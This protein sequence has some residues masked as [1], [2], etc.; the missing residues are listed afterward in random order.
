MTR[1]TSATDADRRGDARRH[2]RRLARGP[3]RRDP[4]RPCGSTARSTCPT[5]MS[6]QEV[7]DAPVRAGGAQPPRRR[8]D[9]ASSAPGCT[10]TTCRRWSTRSSRARSSS[11]PYTPYQPEIS[12]GGL[13]VMFEFQTAISELTGPAGVERL[14]VRGPAR[15]GRRGLPGQARDQ[16]LASSW[17]RAACTRTRA[18]RCAPTPPATGWSRGGGRAHRRGRHRR[19]RAWRRRRR[20]HRRGV[21]AAAQLPRHGRGPRRA[22]RGRQAHRRAVRGGR[23]PA[24]A[25]ASCGRRASSAPTSASARARRSATGSTSAARR[26]ASSPPTSASSAGCRAGSRARRATSTARRGFVLTLQT[27]E[28]H[29]RREKATHNICT[30]QALNALAGVVYLSWLGKRGL[31]ELARADAAAHPLRAR[32]RSG[33]EPINPGPVVRE[34]AV[35]VPR[36]RRAVRARPRRGRSTPATG[37]GATTPSTRTACWWRSPSAA[38]GRDIDR[39][40]EP[41]RGRGR[42]RRCGADERAAARPAR[43]TRR[44]SRSSSA[45]ARA[46]ARSRR[47]RSTC[48][49]CRWR[50]CF[51]RA[52]SGARR[53]SCPRSPSPRSCATS[54]AL[55]KKN[56]DLDTGFYPLGSCTMKHNPKLHERVAALP[57]HARLHPLQD[58]E[59]AQGALELMWRLQGALAEIAGPAARLA[60]AARRLARRAGRPAA[61][62]RLPRGPRRAA[63]QGAHARHRARHQPRH[64]DDGRLRG[65]Q[66]GH[67]RARRR[68]PR[69]PARQGRRR[70]GLPDAH[71]PEHARAVRP[72]HRGDRL[73]RARRG[74]HALL[75][76]GEPE[77][78]D[79]HLAARRHGLRHRPL[80]PAQVLHAAARRRRAG[81]RADRVSRTGSSRSCR[82]RRWCAASERQR[83]R[84]RASTSTTTG[85]SRSASCAASRATSACSCAPTPTSARSAATACAEASETAVL[86]ANYLRA[87]LAEEGVARVPAD[88]LRPHL[89]ARVRAVGRA[90]HATS[91]ASR[92]STSPSG[93]STTS[94]HPPTVYFPLLVDEA[95][96][97]EPTETETQGAA[98]PLR[99][100]RALDPRGGGRGPR[101]RAQRAVH[102]PGAA[103][104]RGRR[105]Q[106]AGRALARGRRESG[107]S[108]EGCVGRWRVGRRVVTRPF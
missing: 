101:D 12:Q 44:R 11:R 79:G 67:R 91:W 21:R 59:Y 4:R 42:A 70:R 104:R 38:R 25:R 47:P 107:R 30:A 58:P 66:G 23:R 99:R 34:F 24:A 35:R 87:R 103:P 69:R 85:P 15:R 100:R 61:H 68:G 48:P 94:V 32:E 76:R 43:A 27:R 95:L 31:V 45:R 82:G 28:Q 93:C 64:R 63:P 90:A 19:R 75:R 55:S 96:M 9:H 33:L 5:G 98:R 62:A 89:H 102:H 49:R 108:A 65:R 22:R 105:R 60:A 40:A 17:P 83:L 84:A 13:Q 54:T 97:I 10:T 51:P 73:D 80:Q 106:A 8:R 86:N 16:A 6:E 50:S 20:R 92:R 2:R 88:R 81:R 14:G 41:W 18:R 71:Q 53:P 74:R 72:Q 36:P 26:S 3:V 57:G 29:I 39:L 52:P 37:S 1:Y 77:R 56:F 7:F 46:G 78:R